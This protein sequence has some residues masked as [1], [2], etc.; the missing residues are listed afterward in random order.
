MVFA[1]GQGH[2]AFIIHFDVVDMA[3]V[4]HESVH[5]YSIFPLSLILNSIG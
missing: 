3:L 5:E 1:V 2:Y 4:G